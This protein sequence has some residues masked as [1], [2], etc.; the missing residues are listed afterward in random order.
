M[1]TITTKNYVITTYEGFDKALFAV[2]DEAVQGK[3]RQLNKLA[4]A[5]EY[6]CA[7]KNGKFAIKYPHNFIVLGTKDI[8]A[9]ID[10]INA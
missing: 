7:N 4:W 8:Q 6:A 2:T 10:L 3:K 5:K 9:F 1:K